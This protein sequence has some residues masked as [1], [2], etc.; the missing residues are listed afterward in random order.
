[1]DVRHVIVAT[2]A[3]TQATCGRGESALPVAS[4]PHLAIVASAAPE[5]PSIEAPPA[6]PTDIDSASVVEAAPTRVFPLHLDRPGLSLSHFDS[7]TCTGSFGAGRSPGRVHAGCDL[8]F[9]NDDGDAYK[10]AY[11]ALNKGTPIYAVADGTIEDYAP[12]YAGTFALVVNHGD[13]VV[14]YGEV[15]SGGLPDGLAVGT[16]V[17][18]GQHIADM[19]D[20]QMATGR[21]AMLH[22]ELYSAERSGPLSDFSNRT[23]LHVPVASYQR[24]ADLA[25]CRPFLRALL[26]AGH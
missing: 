10:D 3:M 21:W 26:E 12:F 2:A 23:Y 15:K 16:A 4:P 13:F 22:F 24:R 14:R 7:S 9:I 17:K 18:A 1:M 5:L 6:A 20:L 11:Y 25:D 19:G 8:Y